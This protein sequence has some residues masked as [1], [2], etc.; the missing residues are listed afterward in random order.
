MVIKK[1][2]G[3]KIHIITDTLGL[4]HN[5]CVTTANSNDKAVALEMFN[6]LGGGFGRVKRVVADQGY[7]G[8]DLQKLVRERLG[9]NIDITEKLGD[10][11][12][13]APFRWV[14][15]RT[16]AWLGMAR[17]LARN[18]ERK[19]ESLIAWIELRMSV[20]LLRRLRYM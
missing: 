8:K 6:R 1:I 4:I 12:Q 18:Y 16:F 9:V 17:R 20:I 3:H 15:E 13:P 14:V 2:K 11:F 7:K 19:I 5:L 10:G